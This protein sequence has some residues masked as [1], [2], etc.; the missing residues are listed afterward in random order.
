MANF[1][2]KIQEVESLV[3]K[4]YYYNVDAILIDE[5]DYNKLVSLGYVGPKL[6][7]FKVEHVFTEIY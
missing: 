6:S 5:G 2:R 7:Q 3:K 1:N 4:I